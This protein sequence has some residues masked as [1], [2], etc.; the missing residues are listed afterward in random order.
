MAISKQ[1]ILKFLSAHGHAPS[2]Y[3]EALLDKFAAFV[4]NPV[5]EAIVD[6]VIDP[7]IKAVKKP[8]A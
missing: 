1:D 8:K 2:G 4:N 7:L 5:V 3:E 6:D